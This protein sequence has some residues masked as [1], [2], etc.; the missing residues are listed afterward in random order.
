MEATPTSDDH[1][2]PT[3]P[4]ISAMLDAIHQLNEALAPRTAPCFETVGPADWAPI[5]KAVA[6]EHGYQTDVDPAVGYPDVVAYT[7]H[8]RT[9]TKEP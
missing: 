9:L 8:D 7:F 5:L 3:A 6:R 2:A 1:R 4:H